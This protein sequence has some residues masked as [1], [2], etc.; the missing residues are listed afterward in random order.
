MS[1]IFGFWEKSQ[2]AGS[3]SLTAAPE[4]FPEFLIGGPKPDGGRWL[5]GPSRRLTDYI[6]SWICAIAA[7]SVY[8]RDYARPSDMACAVG[9]CV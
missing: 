3:D 5:A 7:T 9:S 4:T 1:G 2:M 6:T 8:A